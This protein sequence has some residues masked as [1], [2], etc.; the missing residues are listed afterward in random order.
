ME[1]FDALYE[2]YGRDEKLAVGIVSPNSMDTFEIKMAI[3]GFS[4][5][6]PTE[7]WGLDEYKHVH[8]IL[9]ECDDFSEQERR[10][11][12][13]GLGFLVGLIR[14]GKLS[15][16]EFDIAQSQLPGYIFA[17]GGRF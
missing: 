8:S 1:Q 9:R 4:Y 16:S 11:Y 14:S 17:K 10:F 13:L 2:S 6:M 7:A 15:Q 12:A 3:V 5:N